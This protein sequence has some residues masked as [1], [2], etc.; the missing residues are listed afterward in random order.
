MRIHCRKARRLAAGM[1]SFGLEQRPDARNGSQISPT[2]LRCLTDR[3]A[4]T[5]ARLGKNG[6]RNLSSVR[7]AL[8]AYSMSSTFVQTTLDYLKAFK[9]FSGFDVDYVHVTHHASMGFDFDGYDIVFHSYCARL[10]FEG[11]V[12]ESYREHLRNFP[13]VKV[14]AVQDEYDHTDTLKAAIKD[15]KFDI[16]LTCVPQDSLEYVYPRAEFPDVEFITVFTGYVPDDFASSLPPAKPLAERPIFI[17][18]RGRDIGGRYGRL[19]FDKFEIGRRMKELCD[20]RGIE[21]D[22]AMDEASRIYGTA[23]LDFVGS[24]RAMLGSESGSN[25]FD[26]DGRIDARFKEAT[27]ANG[28]V[29]PSYSDFLP[30]VADRDIEIA[31]G[32]ISPRV[33]ECAIMRTPMV[34]FKGRYSDA[35]IPDEHYISLEKDFSNFEDVLA[36]LRDLPE[37]ENMTRRA[38]GHLVGTGRFTYKTFYAGV[39]AAIGKKLEGR[40][41]KTAG[42]S[43][44]VSILM[45][46]EDGR[47]VETPTS[48]PMGPTAFE[49]RQ[50][51]EEAMN[52]RRQCDTLIVEFDRVRSVF[53]FEL[54]RVQEIYAKELQH[55]DREGK[56]HEEF[57]SNCDFSCSEL[58]KLINYYDNECADLSRERR[59]AFDAFQAALANGLEVLSCEAA[60]LLFNREKCGYFRMI[61]RLKQLN[62]AYQAERAQLERAYRVYLDELSRKAPSPASEHLSNEAP[63][64]VLIHRLLKVVSAVKSLIKRIAIW[65]RG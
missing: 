21:T 35:I 33:F 53:E 27:A 39:A 43:T 16:V 59:E 42:L 38:F 8:V 19:G 7:R 49:I 13:G 4:S 56:S 24:C 26:F 18:Y 64:P 54:D 3:L 44:P 28:G 23:W 20:A 31:M 15:L 47:I 32:Q 11:Y 10:C 6:V 45:L 36:R 30:I 51:V 52:Y 22:I 25:V 48:W 62:E 41:R 40:L 29:P 46:G 57:L 63:R 2:A 60:R 12:S 55:I 14:L 50:S 61:E 65:R 58:T 1:A 9:R 17:G 37:L 5:Y 34:L